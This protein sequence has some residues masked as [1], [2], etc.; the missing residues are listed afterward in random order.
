MKKEMIEIIHVWKLWKSTEWRE[1]T[2][3]WIHDFYH[4]Y[5]NILAQSI[6]ERCVSGMF[7]SSLPPSFI[8]S[9]NQSINQS[10]NQSSVQ[11][12]NELIMDRLLS[13]SSSNQ[14]SSTLSTS[15]SN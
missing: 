11:R 8:H 1:C 9:F 13:T 6:D 7:P 3:S 15:R 4:S 5:H 10:I 14:D 2:S 12:I